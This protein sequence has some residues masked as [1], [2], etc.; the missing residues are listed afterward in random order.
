MGSAYGDLDRWSEALSFLN[1][2]LHIAREVGDSEEEAQQ[3]NSLGYAAVQAN[4]L[5]QAVIR[6]RQALH[7]AFE[8]NNKDDIV[9]NVV[10]LAR[11]FVES[12]KHLRIAKLLIDKAITIEPNDPDVIR[13]TQRINSEILLA[14][15]YETN[16]LAVNGTAEQYA[17]NAYALLEA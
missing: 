14:E 6:Y 13:W 10:A 9:T 2:S 17:A 12:R 16:M 5:P 7:L 8:N 15:A 3:L 4:D 11:L 1:T